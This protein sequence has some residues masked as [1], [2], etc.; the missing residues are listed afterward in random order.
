M[1]PRKANGHYLLRMRDI[2]SIRSTHPHLIV[3]VSGRNHRSE[4]TS[5]AVIL[6][7]II[8]RSSA[9]VRD[10]ITALGPLWSVGLMLEVKIKQ[11]DEGN[12]GRG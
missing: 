2:L 6:R 1:F 12:V 5:A 4:C 9:L 3:V 10:M 7:Q 8:P 11:E